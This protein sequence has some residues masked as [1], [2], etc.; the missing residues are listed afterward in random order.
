VLA[1]YGLSNIGEDGAVEDHIHEHLLA[2]K[3][4]LLINGCGDVDWVKDLRSLVIPGQ[5]L[6]GTDPRVPDLVRS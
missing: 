4:L 2:F 3:E 1:Y 6:D 5:G